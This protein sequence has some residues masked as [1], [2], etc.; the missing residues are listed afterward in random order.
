MR[1]VPPWFVSLTAEERATLL[2]LVEKAT[3]LSMNPAPSVD[4][5]SPAVWL[6]ELFYHGGKARAAMMA[7]PEK[8]DRFLLDFYFDPKDYRYH[9]GPNHEAV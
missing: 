9:R 5:Q 6:D 4:E 7:G 3:G 1:P 2:V 8:N